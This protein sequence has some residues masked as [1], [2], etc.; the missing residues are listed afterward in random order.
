MS[1]K[2][3]SGSSAHRL[4]SKWSLCIRYNSRSRVCRSPPL[5]KTLDCIECIGQ[6]RYCSWRSSHRRPCSYRLQYSGS[7]RA[8]TGC[9]TWNSC[10]QHIHSRKKGRPLGSSNIIRCKS[11][12]RSHSCKSDRPGCTVRIRRSELYNSHLSR[13]SNSDLWE[14]ASIKGKCYCKANSFPL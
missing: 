4:C 14:V 13:A 2:S 7:G 11:G 8:Y 6:L 1:S 5:G 9:I 10:T 3:L 12:S